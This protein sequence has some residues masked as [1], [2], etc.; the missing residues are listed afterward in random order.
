MTAKTAF[1]VLF[2]SAYLL[3]SAGCA[4]VAEQ[5]VD[6]AAGFPATEVAS[7]IKKTSDEYE[8]E[9]HQKSVEELNE[10]YEEF[11]RTKEAVD[12]IEEKEGLS[13]VIIR[14]QDQIE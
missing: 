4:W 13:V 7:D 10:D 6:N 1:N 2:F 8:E 3:C 5:V 12:N 9:E 11:L 14:E